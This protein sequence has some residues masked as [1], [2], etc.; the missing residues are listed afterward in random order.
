MNI[1][2]KI[3]S[4][5]SAS[6]CHQDELLSS[7]KIQ[8]YK[9]TL[10]S[11]LQQTE[12]NET[13]EIENEL[14]HTRVYF[15]RHY[16]YIEDENYQKYKEILY[17]QLSGLQLKKEQ[18]SEFK[19]LGKRIKV[20]KNF[21]A[22]RENIQG[23]L[24]NIFSINKE[25][26]L[27]FDPN[28]E[29]RIK[30]SVNDLIKIFNIKN[31]L[32]I[33]LPGSNKEI[34]LN[35]QSFIASE[36]LKKV[37]LTIKNKIKKGS[38]QST[39]VLVSNRTYSPGFINHAG[40]D[41]TKS[42]IDI[43]KNIENNG[44]L[45]IDF[46]KN[47]KIIKNKLGL[48][49]TPDNYLKI[50]SIFS[51][52][53]SVTM[54]DLQNQINIRFHQDPFLFVMFLM[55]SNINDN[56]LHIFCLAN[57]AKM[58]DSQTIGK[59]LERDIEKTKNE[60]I[61]IFNAIKDED[62][63]E[64]LKVRIGY[65]MKLSC[66]IGDEGKCRINGELGDKINAQYE[67]IRK[68]FEERDT[69]IAMIFEE[70][71]DPLV[72]NKKILERNLYYFVRKTDEE[73]KR[74]EKK[75]D[76]KLGEEG[77]YDKCH[78]DLDKLLTNPENKKIH[79]ITSHIGDGKSIELAKMATIIRDEDKYSDYIPMFYN[80][81]AG[82]TKNK[83]NYETFSLKIKEDIRLIRMYNP[84]KKIVLFFDGIDE[85]NPTYRARLKQFLMDITNESYFEES[86]NNFSASSLIMGSRHGE[87]DRYG[88]AD[89][90]V[91]GFEK[92]DAKARDRYM[93]ERL[94]DLGVDENDLIIKKQEIEDFISSGKLDVDLNDTKII[95]YLLCKLCKDN[96]LKKISNRAQIYEKIVG[97]VLEEYNGT[98]G[99]YIE[100]LLDKDLDD[101]SEIA[102][103]IHIG[104]K[105]PD[106]TDN[107]INRLGI[108]YKI[109]GN[110]NFGFIHHTFYEYFIARYLLRS[111]KGNESILR[112]VEKLNSDEEE[113]GTVVSCN[114]DFIVLNKIKYSIWNDFEPIVRFYCEILENSKNNDKLE[115][116]LG[117]DSWLRNSSYLNIFIVGLEMSLKNIGKTGFDKKIVEKYLEKMKG[118]DEKVVRDALYLFIELSEKMS[119][120]DN[121]FIDVVIEKFY[122]LQQDK[123][124]N[125]TILD[126]IKLGTPKILEYCYRNFSYL[127][128]RGE[129]KEGRYLLN[130]I[131]KIGTDTAIRLTEKGI[132]EMI[133]K[134]NIRAG[135]K[136]IDYLLR[137]G[138][139]N[140]YG[141]SEEKLMD[142][143]TDMNLLASDSIG[144]MKK[145][146]IMKIISRM[147][148]RGKKEKTFMLID[149]MSNRLENEDLE[150]IA[151]HFLERGEII[152]ASLIMEI[153]LDTWDSGIENIRDVISENG[154]Y[155]ENHVFNINSSTFC[156]Y[157]YHKV[158]KRIS[159]MLIGKM[160]SEYFTA[161]I[162]RIQKIKTREAMLV[163]ELI[164]R[165][166]AAENDISE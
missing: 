56:D 148:S 43:I 68:V 60:W 136:F 44:F 116:L 145:G 51:E 86:E 17:G 152:E 46:N 114:N 93:T 94:L 37:I 74:I 55:D 140:L 72:N 131:F 90:G 59:F 20:V 4:I 49:V 80:K 42:P 106:L 6:C 54:E 50:R 133:R 141:I 126:L 19:K 155:D 1:K 134:G 35:E 128:D 143:I 160:E 9:D 142:K 144:Y 78:I 159:D 18:K 26:L 95:L 130:D 66:S 3:N 34:D 57:L 156:S 69:R 163:S 31:I 125:L 13:S 107:K 27:C 65:K 33:D 83:D 101:L 139:L 2:T 39:V 16:D 104:K 7:A 73:I 98:K 108:L 119:F 48:Q 111:G 151:I 147:I 166:V 41:E 45:Y 91:I 8:R 118:F 109:D 15:V 150:I 10:E 137:R 158:V 149:I 70:S 85:I 164:R 14:I 129:D 121:A 53:E 165:S 25:I 82:L 36:E 96:E 120:I 117:S 84:G 103:K 92:I 38:A 105:L 5:R 24:G 52:I 157:P 63:D 11:I 123:R 138:K 132:D 113:I 47:A 127:I 62:I 28:G 77:K 99:S 21:S 146:S 154:T 23:N 12:L 97:M 161:L 153:M 67:K 58:G 71:L 64:N 115:E 100:E 29:E 88:T 110:G 76:M 122:I 135:L 30:T 89:Y 79:I 40:E 61:S 124:N 32:E 162:S 112:K 75:Y 102:Y 87:F 81:P 22:N